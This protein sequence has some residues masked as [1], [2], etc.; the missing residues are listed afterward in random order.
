V[1]VA[2]GGPPAPEAD[3]SI[4]SVLELEWAVAALA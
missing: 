2:D 4:G 3:V 1:Y